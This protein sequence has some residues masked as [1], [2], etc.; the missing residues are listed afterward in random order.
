ME[1]KNTLINNTHIEEI[2]SQILKYFQ[3][4]ENENMTYQNLRY[5][6]KAVLRGKL[7]PLN[8]CIRK[9][10]RSQINNLDFYLSKL[11]K[12]EQIKS[13]VSRKK[14]ESEQKSMKLNIGIN[15]EKLILWK[16]SIKWKPLARPRKREGTNY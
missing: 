16:R 1:I 15:R 14:Q 12:E 7:I 5:A 10:E 8:V 9:E 2:S 11:E 13:I 4:N 6:D 3:L